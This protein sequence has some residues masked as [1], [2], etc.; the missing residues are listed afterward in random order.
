MEGDEFMVDELFDK[1]KISGFDRRILGPMIRQAHKYGL[2]KRLRLE[3]STI[4]AHH[5]LYK[6]VWQRTDKMLEEP[7]DVD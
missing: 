2:V 4:K 7:E 3:K 6:T 1:V 5:G